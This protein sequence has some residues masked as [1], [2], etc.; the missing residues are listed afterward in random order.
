[1]ATNAAL[2]FNEIEVRLYLKQSAAVPFDQ[3]TDLFRVGLFDLV[4][5]DWTKARAS[6][7]GDVESDTVSGPLHLQ[8]TGR[9]SSVGRSVRPSRQWRAECSVISLVDRGERIIDDTLIEFRSS[10]RRDPSDRQRRTHS[11]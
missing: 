1:M 7:S 2:A 8:R 10:G 3:S 11:E 5:R 6:A 4:E 9:E